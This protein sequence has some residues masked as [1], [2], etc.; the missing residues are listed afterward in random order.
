MKH[1]GK[2]ILLLSLVIASC[3]HKTAPQPNEEEN[4]DSLEVNDDDY[5][6][7]WPILHKLKTADGQTRL[8]YQQHDNSQYALYTLWTKLQGQDDS[9]AQRIATPYCRYEDGDDFYENGIEDPFYFTV[10]PD[11]QNLY[12]VACIHANSNGW[13]TNYQ[14]YRIN[15]QSL[16]TKLLT[17]CAAIAVTDNGF[18][19]VKCRCKNQD[20]ATCTAEEVWVMHD[21][22]LDWNGKVTSSDKREYGYEEMDKRYQTPGT[23]YWYLRGFKTY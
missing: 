13:T 8:F 22:H 14:L 6:M 2:T 4:I 18:T 19:I 12:V 20:T 15:C 21:E 9:L 17:E 7:Q 16:E 11:K 1:Y 3:S 5:G 23:E 10:S